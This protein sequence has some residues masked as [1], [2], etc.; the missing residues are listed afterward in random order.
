MDFVLWS[1]SSI[2]ELQSGRYRSP[3]VSS[4]GAMCIIPTQVLRFTWDP[5]NN[6]KSC[7]AGVTKRKKASK[8]YPNDSRANQTKAS[9][10]QFTGTEE[11]PRALHNTARKG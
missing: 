11:N 8:Q 4:Q 2:S 1:S 10:S 3:Q 7:S 9:F 6:M 5:I